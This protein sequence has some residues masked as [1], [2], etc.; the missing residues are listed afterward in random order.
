VKETAVA[1]YRCGAGCAPDGAN[2]PQDFLIAVA[3]FPRA[4]IQNFPVCCHLKGCSY[5]LG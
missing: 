4:A 2:S 5:N 1:A 3:G